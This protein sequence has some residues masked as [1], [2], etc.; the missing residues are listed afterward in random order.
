MNFVKVFGSIEY[1]TRFVQALIAEGH[2]LPDEL[3]SASIKRQADYL[4]GRRCA[5]HCLVL[6]SQPTVDLA[7]AGPGKAPS[8]P[9]Q[10][11]GSISHTLG[12]A[13]CLA[14]T[15]SMLVGVDIEHVLDDSQ[16]ATIQHLV[17]NDDEWR[18]CPSALSKPAFTTLL[19]SAKESIYKAL[20]L[21]FG[22]RLDFQ[23]VSLCAVGGCTLTFV[24]NHS[25]GHSLQA[26]WLMVVEYHRKGDLIETQLL[27]Q[28]ANLNNSPHARV[29]TVFL[30]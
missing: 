7:Y 24:A 23:S 11:A 12:L 25:I 20:G 9:T 14:T 3:K 15:E 27:L 28:K 4:A 19:F 13:M 17:V 21:L 30:V 8:W 29:R 5:R 10:V 16:A 2:V 26:G 22:V 18:H 6:L 1:N